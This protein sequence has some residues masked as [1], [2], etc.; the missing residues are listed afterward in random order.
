MSCLA[1]KQM[2]IKFEDIGCP[3]SRRPRTSGA[4]VPGVEHKVDTLL[5]AAAKFHDELAF[6][7]ELRGDQLSIRPKRNPYEIQHLQEWRPVNFLKW[8]D[9]A[10]WVFHQFEDDADWLLKVLCTAEV[11]FTL[12]R[13]VNTT[14]AFGLQKTVF[15][16][17]SYSVV[18]LHSSAFQ[19]VPQV[20]DMQHF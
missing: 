11:C 18:R 9:F 14:A 2:V 10:N 7:M 1:L 20:I 15:I 19:T 3:K 16:S 5:T 6:R 12:H 8:L 13:N 17:Q 4:A